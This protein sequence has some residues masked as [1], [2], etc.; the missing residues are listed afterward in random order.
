MSEEK[1]K[2]V[3]IRSDLDRPISLHLHET[4][5]DDGAGRAFLGRDLT[6]AT[7]LNP[8]HNAGIDKEFFEK[9]QDQNKGSDLLPLFIVQ[10]EDK[11]ESAKREE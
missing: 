2:T 10:D 1:R 7:A 5:K 11:P 6:T 9:W 8:G 4:I 3:N